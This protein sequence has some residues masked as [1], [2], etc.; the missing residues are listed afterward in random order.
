MLIK[1]TT[2]IDQEKSSPEKCEG[3]ILINVPDNNKF[4]LLSFSVN[5]ILDNSLIEL[6]VKRGKNIIFTIK[7]SCA[8]EDY[9]ALTYEQRMAMDIFIS[10]INESIRRV[11]SAWFPTSKSGRMN[12]ENLDKKTDPNFTNLHAF[13]IKDRKIQK[14]ILAWCN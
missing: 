11:K 4:Q 9:L 2:T 12:I 10:G 6:T 1:T 14:T 8:F 3:S 7:G 13:W 5:N